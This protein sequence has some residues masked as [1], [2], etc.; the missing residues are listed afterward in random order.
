M[1]TEIVLSIHKTLGKH[2]S[3]WKVT[4]FTYTHIINTLKEAQFGTTWL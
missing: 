2:V 4:H 3:S 1:N